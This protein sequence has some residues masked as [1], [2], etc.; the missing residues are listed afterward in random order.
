[1]GTL[2]TPQLMNWNILIHGFTVCFA[3]VD[4][5]VHGIHVYVGPVTLVRKD[6]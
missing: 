4:F 1:M 2:V 6:M 5:F 3:V